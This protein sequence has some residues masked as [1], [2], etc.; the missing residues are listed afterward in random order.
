MMRIYISGK[1]RL[2]TEKTSYGPLLRFNGVARSTEVSDSSD[3]K[4]VEWRAEGRSLVA[5]REF[6][7]GMRRMIVDFDKDYQTCSLK[8][9][10]GKPSGAESLVQQDGR[11]EIQS[12]EVAYPACRVQEGNVFQ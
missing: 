4:E 7:S 6:G 5:Y 8:V 10:F 9:S 2:F 11:T 3:G 1:G 12:I